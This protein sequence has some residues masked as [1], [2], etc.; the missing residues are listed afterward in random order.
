[1]I[2]LSI[3][4]RGALGMGKPMRKLAAVAAAAIILAAA[5]AGCRSGASGSGSASGGGSPIA[6]DSAA[7]GPV[8]IR[9]M[10]TSLS[11]KADG[12]FLTSTMDTFMAEHPG[13]TIEPVAVPM[14]DLFKKLTA[15]ATA[16]DVPDIFTMSNTY[17]ANAVEMDIVQDLRPLMGQQWIDGCLPISVEGASVGDMLVFI[18]WQNNAYAMVYRTDLFAQKNL[19]IP[20]TWDQFIEV[21]KALTEDTDGDG[22]IDRYGFA[23]PGTRNDSAE[24]RFNVMAKTF[25]CEVIYKDGDTFKSGIYD[26]SFIETLQFFTDCVLTYKVVPPGMTQI[27]YAEAASLIASDQACMMISIS[28]VMGPVTADNPE[29]GA[30]LGSFP[31]PRKAGLPPKT[32]FG[33]LGMSISATAKAPEVCADYLKFLTNDANSAAWN[34]VSKRLPCRLSA[35]EKIIAENPAY[36]GYAASSDFA[37]LLQPYTGIAEMYDVVGEAYQNVIAG[38]VSVET[39]AERARRRVDKILADTH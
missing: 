31:L 1:M 33:A 22:T 29:I 26:E 23:M 27:S 20:E 15:L 18:P 34:A 28:N 30:T 39:A 3:Y 16:N 21:A 13:V 2:E 32:I 19:E 10:I 14:N 35:L 7:R 11:D 36:S 12:P 24:S 4:G 5:F 38:G 9:A 25:G 37:E 6:D 17:I 8:H